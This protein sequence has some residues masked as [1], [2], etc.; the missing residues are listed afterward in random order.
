MKKWEWET[1]FVNL[2]LKLKLIAIP[3]QD[4][5]NILD[6]NLTAWMRWH[7]VWWW[8]IENRLNPLT[9]FGPECKLPSD[10]SPCLMDQIDT[11][12]QSDRLLLLLQHLQ[13]VLVLV[14]IHEKYINIY[15]YFSMRKKSNLSYFRQKFSFIKDCQKGLCDYRE[16]YSYFPGD[17]DLQSQLSH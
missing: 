9:P 13:S 8:C 11:R 6:P 7:K 1:P 12:R 14:F 16:I 5:W 2:P 15:Q 17:Y 10:H 3:I 4:T